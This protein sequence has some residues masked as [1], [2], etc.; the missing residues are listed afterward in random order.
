MTPRISVL[1]P[2]TDEREAG[3]EAVRA[4]LGQTV[5]PATF[6]ILA[7]APG[8]DP[9][10]ERGVVPLLRKQDRCVVHRDVDEYELFN[11]GAGE[12]LGEFLILTE[13]HCVPERNFL[14]QMLGELERTGAPAIRNASM[15]DTRG[16]FGELELGQVDEATRA[17]EDPEH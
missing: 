3:T 6:E 2:L 7:L 8:D 17:E 1:L 11:L 9:E 4:W 12:A 14:D 5:D 16:R 10:L 13:A 15:P